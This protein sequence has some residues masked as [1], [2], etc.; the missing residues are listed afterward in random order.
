M[1][2]ALIL[3][4]M[5]DDAMRDAPAA[6][7]ARTSTGVV[8]TGAPTPARITGPSGT[9]S[10]TGSLGGAS[11]LGD[12]TGGGERVECVRCGVTRDADTP[13]AEA[14]AWSVE[15]VGNNRQW[16]CPACARTHVGDIETKL[17]ADYW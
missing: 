6:E 1:P 14:M 4:R 17:P 11:S 13:P 10:P 9:T 2:S 16:L 15:R 3:D 5:V 7:P 12:A 8:P